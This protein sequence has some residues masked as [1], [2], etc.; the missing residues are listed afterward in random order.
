MDERGLTPPI[1]VHFLIHQ[2]ALCSK[3][4]KW[5]SVMKVVVSCVNFIRANGLK[6]RQFQAFLSELE[7]AHGDVL[8]HTEVRWLSRGRV[9]R[10]FYELLPEINA[11]LLTKGK[12]VPELIDTEWKWDLVF[13]TDVTEMLNGLNLQLQGKGKLICDMFSHIKA[14]EVKL[15]LLVGQVQKQDFTHL[16]VTQSLSAEKPAASFPAEKSVEALEML[17]AEFDVRFRELRVHAKEIR[18][19]QNPFAADIDEAMPS[20]QFEIGRASCRERV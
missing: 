10:R 4:L 7:S 6:H 2:Q 8:Y 1:Q 15:A 16:P 13:L 5:E 18:L 12:T 19:F 20:Y 14:F 17:Q 11:F 9:L 3:V